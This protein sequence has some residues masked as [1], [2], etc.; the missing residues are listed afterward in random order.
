MPPRN[1]ELFVKQFTYI[2]TSKSSPQFSIF[3]LSCRRGA[4]R[5]VGGPCQHHRVQ[6]DHLPDRAGP[7]WC[8]HLRSQPG[9]C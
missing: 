7:L 4:E 1:S 9:H 6:T 2:K 8:L 5:A 3:A